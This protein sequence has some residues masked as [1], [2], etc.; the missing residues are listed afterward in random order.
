MV[1]T[2]R[3]SRSARFL[4]LLLSVSLVTLGC[5]PLPDG[6]PTAG[7]YDYQRE[8]LVPFEHGFVNAMGGN[9]V[10]PRVDLS[11]DTL[12]GTVEIGATYNSA[13]RAWT[14]SF[15]ESYRDGTF[16]DATG[17]VHEGLGLLAAGDVVA[18]PAIVEEFGSTIP[19]HPGFR[20]EVDELANV[21]VRRVDREVA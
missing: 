18:G 17:A 8:A 6:E 15:E 10:V 20:A 14:W 2:T 13:T 16:R 7:L 1:R 19:V 21:V 5:P 4:S 11:I 12:I 9:L 3:H